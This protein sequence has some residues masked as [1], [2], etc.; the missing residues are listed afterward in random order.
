MMTFDLGR[1]GDCKEM[2]ETSGRDGTDGIKDG[3]RGRESISESPSEDDEF[4]RS[5]FSIS[6][7]ETSISVSETL[8]TCAG[9]GMDG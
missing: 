3:E 7:S 9:S 8:W 2:E 1:L 6:V 5:E 4:S